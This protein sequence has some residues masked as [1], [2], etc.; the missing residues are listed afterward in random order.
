[1]STETSA[2][3]SHGTGTIV[4]GC[5]APHPPHLV[6]ATNPVQNEPEA[7]GGTEAAGAEGLGVDRETSEAAAAG[8]VEAATVAAGVA[9][10]MSETAGAPAASIAAVEMPHSA[11]EGATFQRWIRLP[12]PLPLPCLPPLPEPLPRLPLPSFLSGLTVLAVQADG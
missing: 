2:P 7:T 1:M 11:V 6:Y 10:A 4:S 5:L 12:L 3:T 8:I 9:N